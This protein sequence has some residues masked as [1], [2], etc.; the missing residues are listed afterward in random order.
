MSPDIVVYGCGAIG[1]TVGGWLTEVGH[2]VTFVDRPES[3]RLLREQG[4]RVYLLGEKEASHSMRVKAVADVR[5]TAEADIVVMAVKNYDLEAAARDIKAKMTREP[6]IVALQNGLDKQSILPKYFAKVVY[7]VVCY[8]AWRDAANV[9][10]Y[11]HKGPIYCGVLDGANTVERDRVVSLFAPAFPCR[12][13]E[14][15]ID[16]AKC[17][18]VVNLVN[19][20]TALVGFGV[21]KIENVEAF[22]QATAHV[23]Y[24]GVQ[25]LQ[26]AGVREVRL[27]HMVNWRTIKAG[28]ALPGFLTTLIFKKNMSTMQISSMAQDVYLLGNRHTELESL[29]GYFLKLA[30]SIG[31]DAKYNRA[32]Y[33]IAKEAFAKPGFTPMDA[34][35]LWGRLQAAS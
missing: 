14:R 31:F 29:N 21:R 17:K 12:A 20:I 35:E 7:G 4:L 13:E 33:R 15:I 3:A 22:K 23:L 25:I 26:K 16:A 32:L 27:E 8:N 19:S 1:A 6:V 18:M 34:G 9:F 10:G 30:D 24:E 5:E 28:I 2:N 11:Q